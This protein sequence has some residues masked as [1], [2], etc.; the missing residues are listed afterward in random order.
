MWGAYYFVGVRAL[1]AIIWFAVQ[2][3]SG[4]KSESHTHMFTERLTPKQ[5]LCLPM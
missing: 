2:L 5:L 3:Y 4:G 1:L